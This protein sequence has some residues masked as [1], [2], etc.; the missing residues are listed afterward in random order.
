MTGEMFLLQDVP[1]EPGLLKRNVNVLLVFQES[2]A[3]K[4][5]HDVDLEMYK[6]K[7]DT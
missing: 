3:K 7:Y 5:K 2:P 4:V 6:S 1:T